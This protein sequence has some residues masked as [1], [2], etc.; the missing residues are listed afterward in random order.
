MGIQLA[1]GDY[2]FAIFDRGDPSS[3]ARA[4]EVERSAGI[5]DIRRRLVDPVPDHQGWIAKGSGE[6]VPQRACLRKLTELDDEPGNRCLGPTA[7]QQ[8]GDEA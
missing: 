4:W 2:P 6:S 7:P 3:R 5:V 8:V 1:Q